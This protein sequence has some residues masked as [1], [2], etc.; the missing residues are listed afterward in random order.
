MGVPGAA[1]GAPGDGRSH[2]QRDDR[3]D[4]RTG[5]SPRLSS[6]PVRVA[7]T[8]T[9]PIHTAGGTMY[10]RRVVITHWRTRH[11]SAMPPAT[12]ASSHSRHDGGPSA[13]EPGGIRTHDTGIKSPLLCH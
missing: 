12:H 13:G 7:H 10:A 4:P 2:A 6:S 9:R 5:A 8:T 1:Q 11:A 3:P